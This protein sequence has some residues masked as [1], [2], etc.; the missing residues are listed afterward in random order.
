MCGAIEGHSRANAG[1]RVTVDLAALRANYHLIA[2]LCAPARVAAVLKADAYGLGV[3]PVADTL[4]GAGCREVFVALFQEALDLRPRLPGHVAIYVLNG[5]AA[6]EEASCAA[7]GVMPVLNSL[8]Q[9][10]RW[11]DTAESCGRP[12]PAALQLDTG[13]SRLG[14]PLD[15]LDALLADAAFRAAAPIA[16]LVTHLACADEPAHPA[17]T[18]QLETFRAAAARI[19]PAPPLSI[20]NSAGVTLGAEFAGDVV[21]AGIGL[22]GIAAKSPLQGRLRDV[23]TL[24]ARVIQVRDAPAGAGVGY[25]LTYTTPGPRRL[26]TL[27]IGYA[28]GWPRHLGGGRATAWFGGHRL[29]VVG[30]VSMDSMTV[31]ASAVP[32]HLLQEGDHVELIGSNA[33]LEVVA[34]AAGTIPYEILVGLG[35]RLQRVYRRAGPPA[36][37]RP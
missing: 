30:R 16:L 17:N 5:L 1:G 29:P 35:P 34:T 33:S 21:R 26:A 23:A 20:A 8:G 3:G 37:D 9:A 13:M 10:R 11:R 28:D 22:F 19:A 25:G 18:A 6:G 32:H 36:G 7:A 24:E 15:D 27:G 2:G 12:L 4:T 14:L 31:D